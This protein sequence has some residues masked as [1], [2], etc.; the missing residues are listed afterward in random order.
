MKMVKNSAMPRMSSLERML[1]V[2]KFSWCGARGRSADSSSKTRD[3][4]L[5]I[6]MYRIA[7][8]WTHRATD[9]LVGLRV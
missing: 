8:R 6:I 7:V 2:P 1:P 5:K 9:R 3:A 4:T